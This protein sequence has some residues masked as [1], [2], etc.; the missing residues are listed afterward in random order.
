MKGKDDKRK[1]KAESSE[2]SDNVSKQKPKSAS[3][4]RIPH[5]FSLREN[6][7]SR[8]PRP[9]C[10]GCGKRI[11]YGQNTI[12][13]NWKEKKNFNYNTISQYH[14]EATCLQKLSREHTRSFMEKR[15]V[16]AEVVKVV[17]ELQHDVSPK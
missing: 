7:Q 12:R 15:W 16:E 5:G 10:Q 14:C 3:K 4:Q 1:R 6:I 9:T 17:R 8:G 13:H 2:E 11:E